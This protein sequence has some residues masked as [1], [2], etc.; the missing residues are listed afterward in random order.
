MMKKIRYIALLLLATLVTSAYAQRP[1]MA[2]NIVIG[3]L[4]ADDL[5]R[6]DK[7]FSAD[8]FRRLLNGGAVFTECYLDYVPSS[9]AASL[10]SISTGT[11]PSSHGVSAER[12]FDRT[13]GNT[14]IALCHKK[15]STVLGAPAV[16]IGTIYTTDHLTA[17]TLTDAATTFRSDARCITIAHEPLSA[18]MLAGKSGECYWIDEKGGWASADCYTNT[19]PDWVKLHNNLTFNKV[20]VLG[21]WFG[22]FTQS[23]Y[24]NSRRSS[25]KLYEFSS[26][27]KT[28]TNAVPVNW[29]EELR[30]TPAGN[31][32]ILEFAKKAINA[33]LTDKRYQGDCKVVNIC[34]DIPRSIAQRYGTESIEYED[35]LYRLDSSL[36]EF[37]TH[38]FSQT[39]NNDEIIVS[40]CA[41][42]GT[43]PSYKNGTTEKE[44]FNARQAEVILNAFLST[45]HGQGKWVLGYADGAIYLNHDLVYERKLTVDSI[46]AEATTFAQQFRCVA[47]AVS[48]SNLQNGTFTKGALRLIQN[49]FY[50]RRSGDVVL[51][52]TPERIEELPNRMADSG[53]PYNYDRHVPLIIYGG[54]IPATRIARRVCVTQL[55]PTLASLLGLPRP[56]SS[57]AEIL[58][59]IKHK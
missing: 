30:T 10:A 39:K 20:F 25:I 13:S 53:S 6:Y 46:R 9:S 28:V 58:T 34:L 54:G 8:G 21:A 23:Q 32:A 57:D 59:E 44:R 33:L 43:S 17:Q 7:N 1:K 31:A 2:V 5:Q 19:L 37:L 26:K 38:L 36:G 24:I 12:W 15:A 18:M 56:Y 55:A 22:K 27:Q 51:W 11:T 52:M 45:R 40:L 42:H 14:E 4:R 16:G 29:V 41:D 35:M 50:P 3:G 47:N 48:A 49:S